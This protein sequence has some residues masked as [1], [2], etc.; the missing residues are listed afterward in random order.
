[1]PTIAGVVQRHLLFVVVVVVPARCAVVLL[2]LFEH[3]GTVQCPTLSSST[4]WVQKH[5]R[6]C[7]CVG[8]WLRLMACGVPVALPS[9][10]VDYPP[11][12][13]KLHRKIRPKNW[14]KE[15]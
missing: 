6:F 11:D 2:F 1:M 13:H 12:A 15:G 8:G 5:P 14:E 10:S 4:H 9:K 3:F 7:F